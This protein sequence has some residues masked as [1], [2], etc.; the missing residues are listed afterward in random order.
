MIKRRKAVFA[1]LLVV[2]IATSFTADATMML[3]LLHGGCPPPSFCL[4]TGGAPTDCLAI[5]PASADVLE[6]PLW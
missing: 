5:G 3:E 2:F 1:I 6:V 4:A